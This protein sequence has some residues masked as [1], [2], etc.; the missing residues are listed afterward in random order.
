MVKSVLD[1]GKAVNE[2]ISMRQ[3]F[4]DTRTRHQAVL[5]TTGH[6]RILFKAV[7][8]Y[9]VKFEIELRHMYS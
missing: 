2:F 3:R 8:H 6:R 9:Y 1:R 4:P 5:L 7:K